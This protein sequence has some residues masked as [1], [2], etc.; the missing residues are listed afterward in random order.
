VEAYTGA[1]AYKFR[2]DIHP[3][4][5]TYPRFPPFCDRIAS[6]NF[7]SEGNPNAAQ[8]VGDL[9]GDQKVPAVIVGRPSSSDRK[10]NP[11]KTATKAVREHAA[12][13]K[14]AHTLENALACPAPGRE[15]DW[16]RR[17]HAA[18]GSVIEALKA[19]RKSA[20]NNGGII[21]EAE[22]L[23]DRPPAIAA[24][25]NQ[26]KRLA[27]KASQLFVAL[28]TNKPALGFRDIRRRGW[29]LA[30]SLQDHRALEA[31]LILEA[32]HLDIGGQG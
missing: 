18:L 22:A 2:C 7:V 26:H 9:G 5:M 30:S 1:D 10:R 21:A 14:A 4:D 8:I 11:D 25:L 19:H 13:V 6:N 20:E 3:T 29:L 23:L 12:I 28:D 16:K 27:R 24:A 32:F 17:V 31:D 15:E